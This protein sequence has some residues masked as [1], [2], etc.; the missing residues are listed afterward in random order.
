MASSLPDG[1]HDDRRLIASFLG[2]LPDRGWAPA[3]AA[4]A[5]PLPSRQIERG[6]RSS[7]Q[8][9]ENSAKI[10]RE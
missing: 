9:I 6:K 3:H 4:P 5:A 10:D 8:P 2:A 1:R 7:P